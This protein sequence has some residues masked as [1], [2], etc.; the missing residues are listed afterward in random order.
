M[1]RELNPEQIIATL[2]TLGRRIHERFPDSGLSRVSRELLAV[3]TECLALTER[4]RRPHWPI[5]IGIG[6]AIAGILAI[7]SA[8]LALLRLPAGIDGLGD[9]V[10]AIE[11]ALNEVILIGVAIF[12]LLTLESRLKRRTA[13]R[14][15]YK[16]R[17]IAHIVDMHQLTKDPEYFLSSPMETPSSPRR[18]MTR[19]ELVRYL[20]YCS[21]LLSVT[22]KLAALHVQGFNDA[23]VLSAVNDVEALTAGLSGKI[24]QKIMILDATLPQ[25]PAG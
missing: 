3:A 5:R 1:S 21:E 7:A 4:L 18:S 11:A 2:V 15:L 13:L 19:F 22:S 17:S 23:V 20:D 9:L 10:Q 25:Q 16:L 14:S 8:A 12:F 24:W 6:V